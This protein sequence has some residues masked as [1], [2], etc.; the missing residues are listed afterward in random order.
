MDPSW[1]TLDCSPSRKGRRS[2]GFTNNT[3]AIRS[4]VWQV[5]TCLVNKPRLNENLGFSSLC[6]PT[7]TGLPPCRFK[8][9]LP[10]SDTGT[11]CDIPTSIPIEHARYE[12]LCS[13]NHAPAAAIAVGVH[14]ALHNCYTMRLTHSL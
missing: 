5:G 13:G 3:S 14:L 1:N 9:C 12:L 2:G 8:L 4:L 6:Q 7:H 11:Q 10:V